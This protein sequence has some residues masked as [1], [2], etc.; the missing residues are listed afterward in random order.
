MLLRFS[1]K[2][3]E[4]DPFRPCFACEEFQA[5][6]VYGAHYNNSIEYDIN[7]RQDG[8]DNFQATRQSKRLICS[9]G[10]T[11]S[12]ACRLRVS[13]GT[14]LRSR[15]YARAQSFVQSEQ[16]LTDDDLEII[17]YYRY[18]RYYR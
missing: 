10:A 16:Y 5:R 11:T 18:Y 4:D 17:R 8:E 15:N 6:T 14:Q 9:A 13:R 7:S 3:P 1:C 12:A 2:G